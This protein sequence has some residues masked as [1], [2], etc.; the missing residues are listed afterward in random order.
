MHRLFGNNDISE[1]SD[2]SNKILYG[3]LFKQ[4][5]ICKANFLNISLLVLIKLIIIA[6]TN[7]SICKAFIIGKQT[8][9]INHKP[10]PL[11]IKLFLKNHSNL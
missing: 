6:N 3:S 5:L 7:K 1:D 8:W 10:I 2:Q 9:I 4:Y 11:I